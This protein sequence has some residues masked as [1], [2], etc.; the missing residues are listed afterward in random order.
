MFP[1][2]EFIKKRMFSQQY[3]NNEH[4]RTGKY[5]LYSHKV[6]TF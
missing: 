3:K 4:S 2:D 5:A 6:K 1:S